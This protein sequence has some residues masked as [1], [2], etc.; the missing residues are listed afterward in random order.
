MSWEK[1]LT[2]LMALFMMGALFFGYMPNYF[3]VMGLMITDVRSP[4]AETSKTPGSKIGEATADTILG[5]IASGDASIKKAAINGGITKIMTVEYKSYNI[6]G[7]FA[8]FT[9]IVT[10]E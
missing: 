10:G 6:M 3:P 2:L 9:T 5:L 4:I 1:I 8:R 7:V